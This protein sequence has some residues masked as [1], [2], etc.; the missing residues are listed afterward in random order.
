MKRAFD[1]AM[2]IFGLTLLFP[3][4]AVFSFLIFLQDFQSPLYVAPRVGKNKKSFLMIKLRSMSS[5]GNHGKFDSTASN[6]PR[7]TTLGKIVR[8]TKLDEILQLVNVLFGEMSLVGP[9]PNVKKETDLYTKKEL[10]LLSVRPGITDLSSI[11]FSD[12]GDILLGHPDPDI[13]YNQLIRPTK[14]K[15]SLYN[16]EQSNFFFDLKVICLTLSNSFNRRWTLKIIRKEVFKG[17]GNKQLADTAGRVIPLKPSPPPGAKN[18]VW[19][20]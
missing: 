8:K 5:K 17:T 11:I 1:I 13:A 16:I 10:K 20:R 2:S 6:D 7:I 3:I 9:R 14:S 4:L 15:I 18:I 19:K 12:E